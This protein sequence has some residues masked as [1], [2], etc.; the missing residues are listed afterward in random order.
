M[1]ALNYLLDLETLM[2]LALT[3]ALQNAPL[4]LV[5]NE[6]H[7]SVVGIFICFMFTAMKYLNPLRFRSWNSPHA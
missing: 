7:G 1:A 2:S 5:H 3:R 4:F 6:L